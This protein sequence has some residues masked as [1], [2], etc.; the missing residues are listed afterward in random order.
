MELSFITLFN[1][2]GLTLP[3]ENPVLKFLIILIVILFAPILLNKIKIPHILGLIIAGAL[4]GPNGIN[5]LK[6]DSSIIMSGT[7]GLLYIMFLAGLEIDMSDFKRNSLKSIVFGMYTFL[8]PM[9]LGTFAGLYI[10]NYSVYTSILLASMFASHTLIV[11]PLLSKYGVT[12]NRAVSIGIGGTMITDTLA[13]LVLAVIVGLTTGDVTNEF[14]LRLSLSIIIF[15]ITVIMLFPVIARWF[16]KRYDDN[17][18]QYIFVLVMVFL[19]AVFAEMAGIEAII[20]AFLSGLALNRLIPGSSPL[21]NRVEFVGNAIFIPFFLIG[22]GMLVDYRAFFNDFETIKVAAIMTI[23]ATVSKFLA[24]WLA[25]KTFKFTLDERRLLFGLSNAQA[26][27]TLAAVTV[28]YNIITG[29]SPD[30]TPIRLLDE[31]ILNGT[32]VMILVTC[33]IATF[34]GQKGAHNISI[35]EM[36]DIDESREEFGERILI[37]LSN[38]KNVAELINMGIMLR[39]RKTKEGMYGLYVINESDSD[40][41]SESKGRKILDTA[42]HIAA[43][44]DIHMHKLLRF[45]INIANGITSVAREHSITD[46][47]IG[48]HSEADMPENFLGNLTQGVLQKNNITAFVYKPAQPIATVKRHFIIVPHKA[49]Y[50]VGFPLWLLRV[51]NISR[52]SGALLMFCGDKETLKVI[53]DI[54]SNHPINANFCHFDDWD[55]FLVLSRDIKP[56]D[57]IIVV[58]SRENNL[59]YH[60]NMLRIPVYLNKYFRQNSYMLIYPVQ[61]HLSDLETIDFRNP[62]M[63]LNELGNTVSKLFKRK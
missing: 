29:I 33:T 28:G 5:L 55:D 40:D 48:L 39:T 18:S 2:S 60:K 36:P 26:A 4:I 42:A 17:V 23:V 20:G 9:A 19:G 57:N 24:A 12:R 47:I 56:D 35:S 37:P 45:D 41:T 32:I 25:Q 51:W 49:E 43:G 21:M 8:I 31:S 61:P 34:V 30:G 6:R 50:E 11:Y 7:A 46:L 63:A 52:N 38:P 44:A 58:L 27:A 62:S 59:S 14:W 54:K 15:G 13:L 10:L 16:F 3:L 53:Q 22:V 1:I